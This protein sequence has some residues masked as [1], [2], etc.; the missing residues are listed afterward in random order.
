MRTVDPLNAARHRRYRSIS[1]LVPLVGNTPWQARLAQV[2]RD[3]EL[4]L[5]SEF[6]DDVDHALLGQLAEAVDRL[7]IDVRERVVIDETFAPATSSPPTCETQEQLSAACSAHG[8]LD[9]SAVVLRGEP[10]AALRDYVNRLGYEVLVVGTRGEGKS[11][12]ILGSVAP[13]VPSF[14]T[15]RD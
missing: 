2:R 10:V 4:R 13:T 14:L 7:S 3:A 12:A 1:L 15:T 9:P 11:R 8:E 5:R 6:G